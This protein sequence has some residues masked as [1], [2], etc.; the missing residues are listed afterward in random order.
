[1]KNNPGSSLPKRSSRRQFMRLAAG[2]GLA[3]GMPALAAEA[4]AGL[5]YRAIPRSGERIPVIGIG[6]SGVFEVGTGD[7]ER[8]GPREVLAELALPGNAV[9]DTSPMY[10]SAEDVVGDL[11]QALGVRKRLFVATKVWTAGRDAGIEQMQ[12]SMQRLRTERIDLM[13]IHN[14]LDWRT[15]LKT[16]RDWK[17]AGRVRYIGITHYHEGAHDALM[18]ALNEFPF[19]FLQVN[20][21]LAEP[22]ADRTLLP[23]ALDKGIAVLVNRPLARGGL[24]GRVRDKP[25]PPWAKE[26]DCENWAQFFLRFVVSHPAVTCAIPGTSKA[27]HMRENLAAGAGRMPDEKTRIR[28]REYLAT[29]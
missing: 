1:M 11:V 16:L 20:Y 25:L 13:Q 18:S 4:P 7:A 14:L 15:H 9:V 19:D 23:M 22:E 29:L 27:R 26:I 8:A 5:L 12:R 24:L 3:A 17:A 2:A 28:M 10:G 6:T 21:S